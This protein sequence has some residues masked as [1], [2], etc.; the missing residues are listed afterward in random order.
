[1]QAGRLLIMRHAEKSED[2]D[3]PHLSP[4]GQRRAQQ[5]ATY[6]PHSFATPSYLFATARSK[7]SYRPIETLDPLSFATKIS[8][9]DSFADQ[10]YGALAHHL[11]RKDCFEGV[12]TAVCWHHGNIPSMMHTLGLADTTYPDPWDRTVFNLILD[13][14]FSGGQPSVH[15]VIEPF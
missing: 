8:I 15:K 1:M 2:P 5:L 12:I 11:L 9:D 4:A 6:I 13:V 10:D 7:H 3:D 14:T